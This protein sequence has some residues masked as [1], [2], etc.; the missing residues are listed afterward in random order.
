MV[1]LAK[2][3]ADRPVREDEIQE[4]VAQSIRGLRL[5]K[6][7]ILPPDISRLY[8]YANV[9]TQMYYRLLAQDCEVTI[10]PALGT[11]QPMT[12]AQLREFF[13]P[14]IPL[15][16]FAVHNWKQDVV[17]VGTVPAAY[18]REVSE[19]NLDFDVDIQINRRLVDPDVDLILSIGQVVP[20]EVVGMANYTKNILVGCGGPDIINKSHMLG[21][22]LGL[23]RI[24]GKDG[25]AVRQVFDYA[26]EHFLSKLPLL[27]VLTVTTTHNGK[28]QV[29]GIFIGNERS[30]FEQAVA[31]SQKK[32]LNFFDHPIQK[33]VAYLDPREF[34]TTWIGNKA[35]YRT[36]MAIADGGELLIIAPGVKGF[37]EDADN[38][39]IIR[40]Y[41][42]AGRQQILQ[43][44]ATSKDL[45]ENMSAAAHL[46]HGSS[47]GRFRVT[48]AVDPNNISQKEIEDAH[49]GYMPLAQALQ[50]YPIDQLQDGF[51]K[52]QDGEEFFYLSNP[53]LGLWADKSKF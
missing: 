48:Y 9:I 12:D 30:S 23:E 3:F 24:M 40:K 16:C 33:V 7:L 36:R 39:K 25:S 10:M 43:A 28:A 53:A 46:I 5:K 34:H 50:R 51:Q 20:H 26:Q 8:S 27:Y 13:G 29:D 15:S 49:F 2:Q 32:N 19:G 22:V 35:I 4:M 42:Y 14:E 21:A 41:G 37:G 31:L 11:H 17:S 47:D 6:V 44:F 38:D 1:Q 52:T 45:Q 18:V